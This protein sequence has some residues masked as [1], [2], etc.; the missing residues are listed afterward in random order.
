MARGNAHVKAGIWMSL[1]TDVAGVQRVLPMIHLSVLPL[2]S[3][4]RKIAVALLSSLELER[5]MMC[6]I[7]S[8][9]EQLVIETAMFRT[10][11][12]AH[13]LSCCIHALS[14]WALSLPVY[15][16]STVLF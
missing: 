8:L 16:E 13:S 6:F 7:S 1:P 9:A 14:V 12:C 3:P 10:C 4:V 15:G 2:L 11:F 5:V